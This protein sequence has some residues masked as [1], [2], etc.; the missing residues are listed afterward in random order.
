[1]VSIAILYLILIPYQTV[2]QPILGAGDREK[3][4]GAFFPKLSGYLLLISGIFLF[5]MAY[6]GN[7]KYKKDEIKDRFTLNELFYVVL[8]TMAGI[9]YIFIISI[10]GYIF[11]TIIT[12]AILMY[13]TR[14]RNWKTN[15][16]YP[17]L[18]SLIV[19]YVFAKL[20]YVPLG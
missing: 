14:L 8:I 4:S 18:V 5:T 9:F 11:S 16:I 20:F 6:L 2:D 1:M 7:T 19:Y 12:I 17:V 3:I 15:I 10:L 13:V